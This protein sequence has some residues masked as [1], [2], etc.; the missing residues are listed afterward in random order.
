MECIERQFN[1]FSWARCEEIILED[2]IVRP[3]FSSGNIVSKE[4]LARSFR[5]VQASLLHRS[6]QK[7]VRRYR[8]SYWD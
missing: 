7:D 1:I 6:V 5:N 3:V 4:V 2:K 8:N